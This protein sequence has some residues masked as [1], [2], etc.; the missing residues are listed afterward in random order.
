MLQG[1]INKNL[2]SDP[3]VVFVIKVA[4]MSKVPLTAEQEK[5]YTDNISKLRENKINIAL[6]ILKGTVG[7]TEIN[8]TSDDLNS[9]YKKMKKRNN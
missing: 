5:L 6:G 8:Y 1:E 9:I 4:D 3:N 2:I 7:E